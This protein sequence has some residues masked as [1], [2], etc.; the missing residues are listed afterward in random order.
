VVCNPVCGCTKS[1][2]ADDCSGQNMPGGLFSRFPDGGFNGSLSWLDVTCGLIV[3][4]KPVAD[5]PDH[6]KT[7]FSFSNDGYRQM[8]LINHLVAFWCCL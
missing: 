7:L 8:D 1:S 4:F 2:K 6:E 5:L 3:H